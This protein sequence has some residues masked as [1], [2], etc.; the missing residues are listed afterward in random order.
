MKKILFSALVLFLC[1]DVNAQRICGT[2]EVLEHQLMTDPLQQERMQEIENF[3]QHFISQ[4]NGNDRVLVTIPVVVHVVWNTS[5]ENISDAQIQSQINVLNA[6]FRKLNADVAETPSAFAGLAADANVQ[7]CLA[8]V[9]P[10]GAATNGITRTQTSVTAFGTNDY[11]KNASTGGKSAWPA[12]KYLNIWVCDISGGILGYAQF[13]GGSASTDGVVIDYMS[14]GTTGTATA[15]FNKGRTATHEIGHWLNLRH[16]WG[17]DGNSCSG[18]D[19]VA[20]T[21]NQGNENYGCPSFP[22]MSCSGAPNGDMFM[23]YMDYTD[24]ACM[25]LFTTG[26]AARMQAL[27]AGGGARAGLLTS[28]GCGTVTPPPSGCGTV[29]G[30]S[31]SGITQT[32]ATMSW[33]AVSG[34]LNYNLDYKLSTSAVYTT[35]NLTNTTYVLNGLTAGSTYNYR[36]QAVC[37]SGA[38]SYSN[39][40]SFS[41]QS[42]PASCVDN[43]ESNNSSSTGKVIPVNTD[44][45]AMLA[46]SSDID[47]FRFRNTSSKRNIRIDLSNLPADYDVRLYK[48][49]GSL[50][51]TSQNAGTTSEMIIYNNGPTGYYYLVVY[52]YNGAY[53]SSQCYKLRASTASSSF[54]EAG[55]LAELPEISESTP[56]EGI[57]IITAFPNPSSDKIE[58][59]LNTVASGAMNVQITDLTGRI[60]YSEKIIVS[61]GYNSFVVDML[62]FA[63][64]Y[65]SLV[66]NNDTARSSVRII[67]E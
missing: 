14:F 7:F 41:T 55:E 51:A 44:I 56:A 33:G 65:Y 12:S 23:N 4:N 61:E 2:M 30:L 15:P 24:D 46:T 67:K 52:G 38:G 9:D 25:H 16:I 58:I 48:P 36:V 62:D 32:S 26:Q 45:Q 49:N 64:G 54:R 8:S 47:W 57:S 11:V 43:Y 66:L 18:S 31:T 21:P 27:F 3:T 1:T 42:P 28:N 20:D 37:S 60:V 34:A 19:L 40:A 63:P 17:D 53:S 39:I 59:R 35:I 29:T 13:P 50:V 10:N 5:A 22:Q 6:D